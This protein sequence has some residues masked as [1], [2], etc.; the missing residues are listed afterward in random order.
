MA[1]LDERGHS[2]CVRYGRHPVSALFLIR[3]GLCDPVGRVIVGRSPGVHLNAEGRRQAARLACALADLQLGAIYASPLERA[4][5]TAAPLAERTGLSIEV[6]A[7]LQELDYGEWTGRPLESLAGD[8]V[9]PRFN[10]D[11]GSTRIPGGETMDEVVVRASRAIEEFTAAHP[12]APVAAVTHGDVIRALLAHWLDMSLDNMLRLEV[13]PGSVSVVR[14]APEP[15]VLAV[16][17]RP[18]LATD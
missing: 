2:G 11:R 14:L 16:N 3:H 9:W 7:D 10:S 4:R 5:E 1:G 17:W 18:V 8:P 6:S 15:R 12:D 13:A